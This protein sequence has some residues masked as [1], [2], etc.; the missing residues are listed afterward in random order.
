MMGN[1]NAEPEDLEPSR[2]NLLT[3]WQSIPVS[4]RLA[5][6][7]DVKPGDTVCLNAETGRY[8]LAALGETAHGIYDGYDVLIDGNLLK[9]RH[10]LLDGSFSI[11]HDSIE[12]ED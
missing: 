4:R 5:V 3:S 10:S 2:T 12:R 8:E 1:M 9:F 6:A 7:P 11:D